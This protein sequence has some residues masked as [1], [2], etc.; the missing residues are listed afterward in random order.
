MRR[1][2]GQ[3]ALA[4]VVAV[5]GAFLVVGAVCG[6]I[7]WLAVDPAEFVRTPDGG[8]AM[9]EVQLSKRFNPDGWYSVIAVSVCFCPSA[10]LPALSAF[11]ESF[12]AWFGQPASATTSDEVSKAPISF[13][14]RTVSALPAALKLLIVALC[15]A[16]R[17]GP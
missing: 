4:D 12:F 15:I 3:G 8:G 17:A 6:V 16:S 9:G 1:R 7:W 5:L 14:L 10:L 2:L 13:M 11:V